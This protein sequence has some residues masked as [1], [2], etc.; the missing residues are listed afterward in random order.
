SDLGRYPRRFDLRPGGG[1]RWLRAAAAD[2][3]WR[4]GAGC[5]G[6]LPAGDRRRLGR[7]SSPP[8]ELR[9][10]DS[11]PDRGRRDAERALL[12]AEPLPDPAPRAGHLAAEREWAGGAAAE[13]DRAR[14]RAAAVEHRGRHA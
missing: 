8:A 10:L 2:G 3:R 9:D 11:G 12:R 6:S 1:E 14:S 13:L 4:A 5:G 7:A